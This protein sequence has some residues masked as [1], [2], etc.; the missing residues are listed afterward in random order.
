[1]QVP[2]PDAG[3]AGDGAPR[4]ITAGAFDETGPLAT[5]TQLIVL[6]AGTDP[7]ALRLWLTKG[8][9]RIDAITLVRL[10]DALAPIE[11]VRVPPRVPADPA[12]E[13][14]LRDPARTVVTMPGDELRLVYALPDGDHELFLDARGYY[15]EW[16]RE[17]WLADESAVHIALL[18]YRPEAALR[19]L[20]PRF[21]AIEPVI[22][23]LFWGSRYAAPR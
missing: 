12:A 23:D 17:E 13:R 20:A 16:M 14:D 22:E 7:R 4:W 8:H 11:P 3:G 15:I 1:V 5:D 19:M 10:D 9:W 21:K 18:L 2:D 6:P